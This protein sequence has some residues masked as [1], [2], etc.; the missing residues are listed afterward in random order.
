MNVIDILFILVLGYSLLAGMYKGFVASG[1]S[2]LG[3]VA[4]WFGA[5]FSYGTLMRVALSNGAHHGLLFQSAGSV[6]LFPGHGRVPGGEPDGG[7]FRL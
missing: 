5:Y 6:F 3:F 4:S 2:L 1:L 7:Q